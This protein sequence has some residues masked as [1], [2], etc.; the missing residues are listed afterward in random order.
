MFRALAIPLLKFRKSVDSW[1]S[2]LRINHKFGEASYKA[3]QL[4]L[5]HMLTFDI[6]DRIGG[7]FVMLP[8]LLALCNKTN[9]RAL[10]STGL[11]ATPTGYSIFWLVV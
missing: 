7:S 6:Y 11:A 2:E 5:V 4:Q 10:S 1:K 9:T 8:S 3:F